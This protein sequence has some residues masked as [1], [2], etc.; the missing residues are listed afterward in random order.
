M[1]SEKVTRYISYCLFRGGRLSQ[2]AGVGELC[3]EMA[4]L[5]R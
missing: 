2:L 4:D 5:G 1:V 3:V